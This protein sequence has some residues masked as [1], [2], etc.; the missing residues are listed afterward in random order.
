MNA[1][2]CLSITENR[3][4]FG[5]YLMGLLLLCVVVHRITLWGM[6][7]SGRQCVHLT[8]A[9]KDAFVALGWTVHSGPYL[10]PEACLINCTL[11]NTGTGTS[12]FIG[13]ETVPTV[14]CGA[15]E[16]PVRLYAHVTGAS[17]GCECLEGTYPLD[18]VGPGWQSAILSTG[19]NETWTIDMV[20]NEGDNSW[21]LTGVGVLSSTASSC[22]PFS[23]TYPSVGVTS[24][25]CGGG[26]ATVTITINTIP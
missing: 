25:I 5:A 15:D 17:P 20:C 18:Y 12:T 23:V 16:V 3:R 26:A 4:L 8:E 24:T 1:L 9:E 6:V 11:D 7:M 21:G 10:T 19:C 14:C 2:K 13:G 22:S